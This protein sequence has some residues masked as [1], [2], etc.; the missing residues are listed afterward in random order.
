MPDE[1]KTI[2]LWPCQYDAR[3][4]VRHCKGKAT[5]LARSV[6]R[7]GRPI[8][9]YELCSAHADQVAQREKLRGRDIVRRG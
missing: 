1:T 8:K 6:D 3:C 4:K 2:E 7:G 5:I 9:Q